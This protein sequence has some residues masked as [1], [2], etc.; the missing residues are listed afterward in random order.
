MRMTRNYNT[1]VKNKCWGSNARL[2]I[3]A[4][5]LLARDVSDCRALHAHEAENKRWEGKDGSSPSFFS[6]PR[7]GSG[8]LQ[9]EKHQLLQ[10]SSPG[11]MLP[12]AVPVLPSSCNHLTELMFLLRCP[13]TILLLPSYVLV[14]KIFHS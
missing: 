5:E 2:L 13:P 1:T 3:Q 7:A 12:S 10:R 8:M 14:F 11:R 9:V 6:H 4:A